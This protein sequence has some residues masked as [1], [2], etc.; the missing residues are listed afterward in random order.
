MNKLKILILFCMTSSSA[1]VG[2]SMTALR[3]EECAEC[4]MLEKRAFVV[5][6]LNLKK[7]A[8]LFAADSFVNDCRSL[9]S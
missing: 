6:G 5:L 1:K 3:T 4:S 9:K 8:L 7:D 2:A